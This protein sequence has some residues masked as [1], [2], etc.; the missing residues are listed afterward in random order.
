MAYEEAVHSIGSLTASA[1]LSSSQFCLVEISGDG[2]VSKCNAVT[3]RALGVLLDKPESGQAAEVAVGGIVKVLAGGAITA[4]N[5]IGPDASGKGV[6]K[7]DAT[8]WAIGIAVETVALAATPT[9]SEL[10]S[11]LL[12]GPFHP[13]NAS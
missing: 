9:G 11:V 5:P 8:H 4:G 6:A 7:T 1:D 3:D 12:T 13:A 10:V 2:T